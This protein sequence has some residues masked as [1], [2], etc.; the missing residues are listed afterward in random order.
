MNCDGC[1]S[2]V[3]FSDVEDE[4]THTRAGIKDLLGCPCKECLIKSMCRKSC[5]NF[6]KMFHDHQNKVRVLKSRNLFTDNIKRI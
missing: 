4:C 6:D 5:D 3:H 2:F 1:Y